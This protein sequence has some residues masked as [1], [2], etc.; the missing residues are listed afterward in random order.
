M[1][2]HGRLLVLALLG[3]LLL[4]PVLCLLRLRG[5]QPVATGV[6]LTAAQAPH[7]HAQV[8][9]LRRQL[10]LPAMTI[11]VTPAANSR[12]WELPRACCFLR[13]GWQLQLGIVEMQS[14]P[15]EVWRAQLLLE[16]GLFQ[17]R[18]QPDM[19]LRAWLCRIPRRWQ[20][21]LVDSPAH[22]LPS[23]LQEALTRWQ[24]WLETAAESIRPRQARQAA[25]WAHRLTS[26]D[27][28]RQARQL[29]QLGSRPALANAAANELLGDALV[30]LLAHFADLRHKRPAVGFSERFARRQAA[31]QYLTTLDARVGAGKVLTRQQAYDRAYLTDTV[32]GD[33]QGALVQF[34]RL[35]ALQ[36]DDAWL[37]LQL[38]KRLLVRGDAAGVALLKKAAQKDPTQQAEISRR[39]QQ[40]FQPRQDL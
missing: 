22:R 34:Q 16:L 33:A 12:L 39:L 6:T 29:Q 4:L 14:L 32:G 3:N 13:P 27:A 37:C 36:P 26:G 40:Y 31:R 15:L 8:N 10:G 5:W 1:L 25:V 7:L 24:D 19:R 11:L 28:L 38:G 20:L 18:W 17:R 30:P 2:A 35:H 23:W 21:L 9:Q